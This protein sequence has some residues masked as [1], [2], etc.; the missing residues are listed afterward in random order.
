ML[1][2]IRG[3][4]NFLQVYETEFYEFFVFEASHGALMLINFEKKVKPNQVCL[5]EISDFI[6]IL[7]KMNF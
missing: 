6:S 7:I 3:F 4:R 1:V 2:V 5:W